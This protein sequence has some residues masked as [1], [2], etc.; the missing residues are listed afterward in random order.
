M[1]T[2]AGVLLL[3]F[4]TVPALAV[5]CA[6]SSALQTPEGGTSDALADSPLADGSADAVSDASQDVGADSDGA[7]GA[8][9]GQ[10]A[11]ADGPIDALPDAEPALGLALHYKLDSTSGNE[12]DSSGNGNSGLV[13]GTVQR[14]VP[15]KQG[16][17]FDFINDALIRTPSSQ[18]LDMLTGGT[19]EFWIKL[20]SVATGA[21]LTRGT[22][23][24]DA[25]RIRTTAGN[26]QAFFTRAGTSAFLVTDID[27]LP[28]GTWAHVGI[29][30][31][32]TSMHIYI[33]GSLLKSGTGGQL[34]AIS[35]D[36]YVGRNEAG[37]VS[38]NGTLDDLR[39]WTVAR[40]AS[41]ICLD[42][43]GTPGT[44]DGAAT[45]ALP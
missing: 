33:D 16:L 40:T 22:T 41:E 6:A 37:E 20:S 42:A 15:G 45:C 29:V 34:G 23:S 44:A 28:T 10:D 14:G 27:V 26:I 7:G 5:S 24:A 21:I 18:S 17:A 31:D 13:S 19:I 11:A 4:A 32:G 3:V 9:S 8:D 35:A 43:G 1:A 25:I 2:R 39:W 36:L 38:L 12:F 30:N